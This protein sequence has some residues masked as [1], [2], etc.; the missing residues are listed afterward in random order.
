MLARVGGDE[1]M[2]ILPA[3]DKAAAERKV[4][5]I[6]SEIVEQDGKR[7]FAFS[8]G[9]VQHLPSEPWDIESLIRQ[10]DKEMY[11]DKR[12]TH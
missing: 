4:C 7:R 2:I 3:C 12:R 9:V 6:R 11:L 5:E 10:A 8:Y 1:F